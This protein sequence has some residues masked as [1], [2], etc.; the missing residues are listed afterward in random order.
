M[1]ACQRRMLPLMLLTAVCVGCF[2]NKEELGLVTGQVTFQGKPVADAVVLFRDASRGIHMRAVVDKE[3]RFEVSMAAGYGL[4]LGTYQIGVAPAID[5]PK[6]PVDL[7]ELVAAK[8]VP[9]P[10][11]PERYRDTQT[12]GLT[13]AV[14][15]G[16]NVL[17]IEME[18]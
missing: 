10:D 3:G 16:E 9:R 2:G 11:I 4:P 17:N 15:S 1:A 5:G 7:D 18:P 14:G 6:G 12:S 8:P 13:F